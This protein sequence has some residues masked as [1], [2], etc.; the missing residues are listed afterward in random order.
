MTTVGTEDQ[1]STI[2][3]DL[4][5][6]KLAACVNIFPKVKSIYR[7]KGRV[8]EDE[9]FFLVIKTTSDAL[10]MAKDMIKSKH[11]YEIPELLAFP[12]EDI[13]PAFQNW[14]LDNIDI[15]ES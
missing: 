8:W 9:E 11:E 10:E 14:I 2:A 13:D 6:S 7:F 3:N 15:G 1:A 5:H 12:P 4:V